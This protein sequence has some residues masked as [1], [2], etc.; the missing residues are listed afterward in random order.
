MMAFDGSIKRTE[1]CQKR[2]AKWKQRG[3][4]RFV[5]QRQH[6]L[7]WQTIAELFYP[8]RA[9]MTTQW[10]GGDERYQGIF[11][12]APQQMRRD[13]SSTL[14]A[15]LRPRGRK[16]FRMVVRP[17]GLMQTDDI[18]RWCETATD[19]QWTIVYD[20]R[21]NFTRAMAESD[22][23]YVTFGNSVLA[24]TYNMN[25]DGVFFRCCHLRDCAWAENALGVVDELHEKMKLE[26]R[27]IAQ[28]FGG[29]EALPKD[30]QRL[31][32]DK[33][34]EKKT[35]RRCVAPI[36]EYDYDDQERALRAKGMQYASIYIAE[37]V[38][39]DDCFLGERYFRV[40]PYLVRR[41]MT[42]SGENYA[43]S[44][45]TGIALADGRTLNAAQADIL[46]SIEWSVNPPRTA[47]DEAMVGEVRLEAGSVIYT[48]SEYDSR[49]GK[50]FDMIETGDP[51]YGMELTD[52]IREDMGN[53]FF[54]NVLQYLPDKQM[55]AFEV[56]QHLERFTA[57]A[58]PIFEPMEA[59]NAQLMEGVF[60][61]AADK[62]AFGPP[63]EWPTDLL[64]RP[65]A[66]V[67]FE[68]ETPLSD[69]MKKQTL[70]QVDQLT[71][72][73][74]PM[75]EIAP[76]V[77]DNYDFDQIARDIGE[78]SGPL[79]WVKREEDRNAQRQ[80]AAEQAAAREQAAMALEAGKAVGS[81]RPENLRMIEETLAQGQ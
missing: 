52:R 57:E 76:Q 26:L 70:N 66:T 1:N 42:V 71:A 43:R 56:G 77:L 35:I 69:A 14:G 75:V 3:D 79:K 34:T 53:A 16:W 24:H 10:S 78:A 49:T 63:E 67:E 5:E 12:S 62:E 25:Q 33:P 39:D 47:P 44:M 30:W 51:R 29:P 38:S 31:L 6:L 55:T 7:L 74:A 64:Q 41:W 48:K 15:M 45:C 8:E 18:K 81:A 2:A 23:D 58:A 46:Q 9:D 68:F 73:I 61:R 17:Q 32:K 54:R 59:D 37:G 11:T 22:A 80:Q 4:M 20:P 19:K 60:Y 13:L 65:D 27:Q 36:E 21:A 28:L 72:R 50:P 40:F